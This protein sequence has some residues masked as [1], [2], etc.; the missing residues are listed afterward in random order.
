MGCSPHCMN[1]TSLLESL[2]VKK[3][4]HEN[5]R[6]YFRGNDPDIQPLPRATNACIAAANSAAIAYY[7]LR[8]LDVT[9]PWNA[10]TATWNIPAK[11]GNT[12]AVTWNTPAVAWTTS[13]VTSNTPTVTRSTATIAWNITT[14]ARSTAAIAWN[15]PAV[16]WTTSTDPE[17]KHTV[18]CSTTTVTWN[19]PVVIIALSASNRTGTQETAKAQKRRG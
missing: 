1:A 2:R 5:L 12:A 9:T 3:I 15:T 8:L 4:N 7:Q 14:V 13:T 19:N 18:A 10:S 16:A 11:S 17:N 6:F